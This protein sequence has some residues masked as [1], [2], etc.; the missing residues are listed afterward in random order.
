MPGYDHLFGQSYSNTGTSSGAV[1]GYTPP[2]GNSGSGSSSSS[3]SSSVSNNT[4]ND[5][6]QKGIHSVKPKMQTGFGSWF[7]AN[8]ASTGSS[9]LV[10]TT[11][12]DAILAALDEQEKLHKEGKIKDKDGNVIPWQTSVHNQT[13]ED[14]MDNFYP[15]LDSMSQE[16]FLE[17]GGID[18]NNPNEMNSQLAQDL[19]LDYN[20]SSNFTGYSGGT[21]NLM[22]IPPGQTP[23]ESPF[24][25]SFPSSGGGGG[26]SIYGGGGGG[27]GSAAAYAMMN[28]GPK[29]LGEGEDVLGQTPL[30][31]Y[32]VSVNKYNPYTK[33]ALPNK[34]N[35]G[36]MEL[37]R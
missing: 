30:Q 3:S 13:I 20:I 8:S 11:I 34:A 37:V 21:G 29:Q 15:S 28:Q 7:G 2:S 36:I 4:S 24:F 23:I 25:K 6:S 16:E 5:N 12:Q 1:G 17:M 10:Q 27:D 35:G 9:E 22:G 19:L 14:V 26:G 32:M 31:E 18:V 33:M